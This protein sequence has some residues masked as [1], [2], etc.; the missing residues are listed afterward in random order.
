MAGSSDS[1]WGFP[2]LKLATSAHTEPAVPNLF[3]SAQVKLRHLDSTIRCEKKSSVESMIRRLVAKW[4][5]HG[6]I[7]EMLPQTGM[8]RLQ[9]HPLMLNKKHEDSEHLSLAGVHGCRFR[10]REKTVRDDTAGWMAGKWLREF[11]ENASA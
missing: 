11:A 3:V 9:N 10:L 6:V 8:Q 5:I 1:R 4:I 2:L 7:A